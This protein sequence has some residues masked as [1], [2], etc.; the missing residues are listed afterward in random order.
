M[1]KNERQEL[2]TPN[3]Y[4]YGK[5]HN[6]PV[7]AIPS[8]FGGTITVEDQTTYYLYDIAESLRE[9]SQSLAVIAKHG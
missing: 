3:Y 1:G 5:N 2:K 4:G 9:I 8:A 7:K 6:W